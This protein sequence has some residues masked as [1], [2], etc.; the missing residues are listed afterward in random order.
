LLGGRVIVAR[1]QVLQAGLGVGVRS[2]V[3][4]RCG[5]VAR[6]AGRVAVG[7]VAVR[8]EGVARAVEQ[9]ARRAQL[10]VQIVLDAAVGVDLLDGQPVETGDVARGAVLEQH[11]QALGGVPRLGG[12]G[13]ALR[14]GD[15]L[16]LAQ[17]VTV[18][19]VTTR[20]DPHRRGDQAVG[21]VVAVAR[22]RPAHAVRLAGAVAVLV[23]WE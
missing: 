18:V 21:L 17:A 20:G 6:R 5:R 11:W 7:V 2:G 9:R 8:D 22:A 15:G 1:L 14:R 12:R 4:K 13:R 23:V 10:V 19:A 16:A 3:A